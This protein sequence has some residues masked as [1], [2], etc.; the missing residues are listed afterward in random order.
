MEV[1]FVNNEG[2]GFADRVRVEEGTTVV[3]F[4]NKHVGG[5]ADDYQIRVNRDAAEKYQVL[6]AND[7]VT[8]TPKKIDGAC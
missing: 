8:V 4:F 6:E 7:R 2:G 1:L 5:N 3:Q